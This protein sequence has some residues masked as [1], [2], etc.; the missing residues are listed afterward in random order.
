MVVRD[1]GDLQYVLEHLDQLV[2]KRTFPP[3]T[4][5][6]IFGRLLSTLQRSALVSEIARAIRSISSV[7]TRCRSRP[8]L[9]GTV[10]DSTRARSCCACTWPRPAT[11]MRSCLAD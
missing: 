5:Q 7:R 1:A 2:I 9:C 11:R 4:G 3:I 10:K 8:R 6:P